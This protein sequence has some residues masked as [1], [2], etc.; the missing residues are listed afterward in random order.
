M[1]EDRTRSRH[2]KIVGAFALLNNAAHALLRRSFA[3]QPLPAAIEHLQTHPGF[4][5]RLVTGPPAK[6]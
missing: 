4:L 1:G 3:L 2:P 6:T 5:L